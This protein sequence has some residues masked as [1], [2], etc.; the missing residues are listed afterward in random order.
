MTAMLKA[1]TSQDGGSS[2]DVDY[3]V[4]TTDE[5][6]AE[7]VVE[8]IAEVKKNPEKAA[9]FVKALA[10]EGLTAVKAIKVAELPKVEKRS[11][12]K[13]KKSDKDKLKEARLADLADMAATGASGGT[14]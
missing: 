8:K 5:S 9:A 10:D 6:L 4:Y 2:V 7:Q 12:P 3:S 11:I 13:K 1:G 14:G